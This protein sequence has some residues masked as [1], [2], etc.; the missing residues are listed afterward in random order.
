[1]THEHKH[2]AGLELA[3][4]RADHGGQY[5]IL[6]QDLIAQAKAAPYP[7]QGTWRC[8]QCD[9]VFEDRDSAALHF[10]DHQHH[11]PACMLDVAEYRD[12]EARMHSYNEEDAEIHRAMARIHNQHRVELQREEEK[13][14]ARGLMDAV[15]S[16]PVQ[17]EAVQIVGSLIDGEFFHC[18]QNGPGNTLLMTVAQHHRI[19]AAAK[20]DAEL[21]S[22]LMDIS[23]M[24]HYGRLTIINC[25]PRNRDCRAIL[26]DVDA[27]L[28][29][30]SKETP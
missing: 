4:T 16:E 27:K 7:V 14:Y 11:R 26:A 8:F 19:M 5:G 12:M 30:L 1:M 21:V 6:L 15:L 13:G 17:G 23:A 29:T 3:L 22:L 2:V 25:Y 28:A 10:G 24:L 18:V 9:E 20:P